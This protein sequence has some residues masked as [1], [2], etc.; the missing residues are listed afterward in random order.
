[1]RIIQLLTSIN[2]I[3]GVSKVLAKEI[4]PF[5]V[6]VLNVSLGAFNTN[7]ADAMQIAETPMDSDYE[8]S[9]CQMITNSLHS[10]AFVLDGDVSKA[11]KAIYEVVVG[12]GVGKGREAETVLPLGRDAAR[13]IE[14]VVSNWT[15]AMEIFG[16]V[17]N[18]VYVE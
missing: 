12:E 9:N 16:D 8:G 6:R 11:V 14:G 3:L 2:L 17:C 1:M 10:G 13:T 5:N 4:S 15:H 7:F 18:N